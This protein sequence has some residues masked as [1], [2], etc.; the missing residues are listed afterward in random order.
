MRQRKRYAHPSR[1]PAGR[2]G[3]AHNRPSSRRARRPMTEFANRRRTVETHG[4]ASLRKR[5]AH[6]S[7]PPAGRAGPAHN[8]PSSRRARR[9]MTEFANRR[10]T[11]ETHGRAS[12]RKRYAHPS[13]PPAGR[14]GPAHNRPSSR[15]APVDHGPPINRHPSP[16]LCY[17]TPTGSVI[18]TPSLSL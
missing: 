16:T 8:R 10:R 17:N 14:A 7:R 9:P 2:A 5:Y 3:P 12:L 6:P 4:R 15:R 1:P 18:V 13:R 11:V